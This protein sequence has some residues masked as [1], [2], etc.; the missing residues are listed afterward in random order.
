M[1]LMGG[2]MPLTTR[3][4]REWVGI[5][6][7]GFSG[8]S[9]LALSQRPEVANTHWKCNNHQTGVVNGEDTGKV[10]INA[11]CSTS[12]DRD[13]LTYTIESGNGDGTGAIT[14]AGTLDYETAPTYAL[15]V[16]ADDGNGDTGTTTVNVSVAD[17]AENSAGP[18]TGFT[19]ID[20][21]EHS[22]SEI[23]PSP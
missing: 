13:G 20:A 7:L 10:L 19:L 17:A 12:A 11:A 8:F 23:L 4:G 6:D 18:L 15:T 21:H 9:G 5:V 16:Q 3:K 1:K 22:H 2:T 14:V